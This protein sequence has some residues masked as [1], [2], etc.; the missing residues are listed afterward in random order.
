MTKK[1]PTL[2]EL[3]LAVLNY[4]QGTQDVKPNEQF[5]EGIARD[6][7]YTSHN[8]LNYKKR[9]LADKLAEYETAKE[10]GRDTSR[11]AIQRLID[12]IEVEL[13]LLHERHEADLSV[14]EQVTGRQWE[15]APKKRRPEQRSNDRMAALKAKVA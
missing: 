14:F 4:W 6:E 1:T 2:V 11:Y 9:Q 13:D 3:K 10:E 5:I 12:A 8:S 7:C 15:P